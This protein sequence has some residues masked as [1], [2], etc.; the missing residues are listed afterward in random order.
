MSKGKA[1]RIGRIARNEENFEADTEN[2]KKAERFLLQFFS[3]EKKMRKT[4]V[5]HLYVC[6]CLHL[7]KYT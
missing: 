5:Q 2:N 7:N 3:S 6:I 4:T 1:E